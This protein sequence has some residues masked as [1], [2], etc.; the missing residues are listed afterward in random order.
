M[1]RL[2]FEGPARGAYV[3]MSHVTHMYALITWHIW[4][5]HVT[6]ACHDSTWLRRQHV[7]D[8]HVH[9]MTHLKQVV[10]ILRGACLRHLSAE[11]SPESNRCAS[12][13]FVDVC[14]P[15][16]SALSLAKRSRVSKSYWCNTLQHA[17]RQCIA[18]QYTAKHGNTLQR[19]PRPPWASPYVHVYVHVHMHTYINLHIYI[20]K[21]MPD[22]K[23]Q[24]AGNSTLYL[25][26]SVH[27]CIQ[28]HRRK[29]RNEHQDL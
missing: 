15:M 21:H 8:I 28:F 29:N 20:N 9:H 25:F 26:V 7:R 22:S 4:M 23:R 27:V 17:W 6:H 19:T 2:E 11:N 16:A 3:W 24:N 18:L 5:S 12:Y 14:L 13:I 1:D 10:W